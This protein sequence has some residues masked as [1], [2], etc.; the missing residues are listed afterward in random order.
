LECPAVTSID[1]RDGVALAASPQSGVWLHQGRSWRHEREAEATTVRIAPDGTLLVG[2]APPAVY[3]S[4]GDGWQEWDAMQNMLRYQR[5]RRVGNGGGR[6]VAGIAFASS[7]TVV[8]VAGAGV[9]LTFDDG[10]SWSPHFEGLD[11]EVRGL[12]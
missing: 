3:S 9:F 11:P 12:W 7:G 6:E 8:A 5:L 1:A 4:T 2:T 10:R